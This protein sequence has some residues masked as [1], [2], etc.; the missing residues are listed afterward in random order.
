MASFAADGKFS[1]LTTILENKA[2]A[3]TQ[4][5]ALRLLE[6]ADHV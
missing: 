3:N 1:N 4:D 2:D 5:R 6:I